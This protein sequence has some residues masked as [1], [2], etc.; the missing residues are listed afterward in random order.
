MR[1]VFTLLTVLTIA[2]AGCVT[3][4]A[5]S[6][7]A[8]DSNEATPPPA[9]EQD[10][11]GVAMTEAP[12]LPVGRAWTYETTHLYDGD[13][14]I[15]IVVA[16][17]TPTGYL[18]AGATTA[19]LVGEVAWGRVW[20]GERD[21][22]L[23]LLPR[24]P[25]PLGWKGFDFPLFDGKTWDMGRY[26]VT[27]RATSVSTPNGPEDGYRI[28]RTVEDGLVYWDYAPSVGYFTRFHSEYAGVVYADLR[29]ASMSTANAWTWYDLGPRGQS[30]ESPGGAA[31]LEVPAGYDAVVISAGA[32]RGGRIDV[33][34]PATS[35]EA[36]W[37]FASDTDEAWA[38]AVYPAHEG[39][40]TFAT[41]D[42][43]DGFG[44]VWLQ[45]AK[46][47]TGSLG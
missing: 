13:G 31:Q 6:V 21:L 14:P 10:A 29:L 26:D 36:P 40:W 8:G 12:V 20:F 7:A 19:D 23:R 37:T 32:S 38:H 41:S 28:E 35:R 27:A 18:F 17:A 3:D 42:R 5:P 9:T 24:G 46:W 2:L 25:D 22:G 33:L 11:T 1:P 15:T 47:V 34:P 30:A 4:D 45:V 39:A 43:N 16:R 44:G